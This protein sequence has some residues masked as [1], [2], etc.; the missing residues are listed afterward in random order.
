MILTNINRREQLPKYARLTSPELTVFIQ[1]LRRKVRGGQE[2]PSLIEVLDSCSPDLFP[3]INRLLRASIIT[4]P[5]TSCT[6]E[7]LL[8]YRL[9]RNNHQILHAV[10]TS[11][12]SSPVVLWKGTQW[13]FELWWNN[14]DLQ[15]Q[16][17]GIYALCCKNVKHTRKLSLN[18]VYLRCCLMFLCLLW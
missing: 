9:H 3:D 12:Q 6:V 2:F 14:L 17:L 18:A 15:H 10:S 13:L 1:Q 5:M 16:S 7:T 11:K 8:N 4:L